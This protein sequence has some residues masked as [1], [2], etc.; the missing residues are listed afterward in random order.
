MHV[1]GLWRYP[2]KSLRGERLTTAELT[3]DGV[4]GDRV[5]HVR[6]RK[7]PLTGRTRHGLLTVPAVTG[8]DGVPW[9][10]GHRWDSPAAA[11]EIR[12]AVGEPADLVAYTG[13][14]RFDIGNLLVAT[15]GAVE[16]FGHDVRRLRPNILVGGTLGDE[17]R[18]WEGRALRIGTAVVGIFARRIRCVVTS[19]DPDSGEQDLDVFREIRTRFDNRLALDAW[20]IT[21]GTIREGDQVEVVD[22]SAEPAHLG[23]W[24][25]GAPYRA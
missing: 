4:R 7:G 6:G 10:A 11:E 3:D 20:V 5:V 14:E 17:E 1:E 21:P 18:D 2:V 19:I 23:G 25:V 15:D 22:T 12:R 16:Q 13:P 8:D 9:V 24:I